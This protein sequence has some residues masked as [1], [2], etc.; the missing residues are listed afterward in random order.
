M[1]TSENQY[2]WSVVII[3][4][5]AIFYPLNNMAN[6]ALGVVPVIIN[7]IRHEIKST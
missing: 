4:F 1:K 6:L 7:I 3:T 2:P 5:F